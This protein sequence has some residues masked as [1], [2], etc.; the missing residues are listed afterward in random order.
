[1]C[2][3]EILHDPCKLCCGIIFMGML[4]LSNIQ[5]ERFELLI[6]LYNTCNNMLK[7]DWYN[8]SR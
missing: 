3:K 8:E 5:H 6:I 7:W 1:M 2:A 4:H